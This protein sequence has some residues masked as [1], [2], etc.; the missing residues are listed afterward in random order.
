MKQITKIQTMNF[1]VIIVYIKLEIIAK[2][3]G[4]SIYIKKVLNFKIKDGLSI[5][6]K[7]VKSLCVELLFENKRNTLINVLYRPPNG[8][9]ELFEKFSKKVSSITKKSNKVHHI[10][11]DFNLNPLDPENS[12]KIQDFLIFICQNGMIPTIN[13]PPR[14][15][16]KTAAAINQ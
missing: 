8:Q 2:G 12:T 13:K 15:I 7:D 6:C 9:T 11:R 1:Q 16:R 10:A 4:V 5:N 14:V 3:G